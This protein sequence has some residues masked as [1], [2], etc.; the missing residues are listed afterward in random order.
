MLPAPPPGRS[1]GARPDLRHDPLAREAKAAT[2]NLPRSRP[3]CTDVRCYLRPH[4]GRRAAT[5]LLTFSWHSRETNMRD[6]TDKRT[7]HDADKEEDEEA[8]KGARASSAEQATVMPLEVAVGPDGRV[9]LL[10]RSLSPSLLSI[11]P[12]S[13]IRTLLTR[14][15]GGRANKG[16]SLVPPPSAA[17]N[18]SGQ[19]HARTRNV[20]AC[21][22]IVS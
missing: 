3:Y 15:T 6:A 9:M 14:R 18:T 21:A 1:A 12:P 8:R 2:V 16:T 22:V 19:R 7:T 10:S 4:H 17:A 5:R 11:P 20:R 13:R